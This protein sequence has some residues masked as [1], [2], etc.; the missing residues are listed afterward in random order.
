MASK[1]SITIAGHRTSISLED[2]FWDGLQRLAAV[3][4][5]AVAELVAEI[6]AERT[7]TAPDASLSSA[8]RVRVLRAV[9]GREI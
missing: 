5:Q 2:P 6:D 9:E 8:L 1:R 4:G 7:A 3:R